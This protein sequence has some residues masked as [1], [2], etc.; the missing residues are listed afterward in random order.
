MEEIKQVKSIY[1]KKGQS[2]I[3]F[4]LV[5]PLLI[6]IILIVSQLGYLVY[7]QNTLEQAAREGTRIISTTNSNSEAHKQVFDICQSLDIDRISIDITPGGSREREVGETVR[8]TVNYHYSGLA[9]LLDII[10]GGD[11]FIKS[12]SIMRMESN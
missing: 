10:S 11:F 2:S 1:C 6:I 5:L 7:L 3:E 4:I 12:S 8:V 9:D